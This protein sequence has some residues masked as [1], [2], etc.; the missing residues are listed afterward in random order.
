MAVFPPRMVNR[1]NKEK[2]MK[3]KL[4]IANEGERTFVLVLETGED[5][6]AAISRFATEND[7]GGASLTAIGAFSRATVGF[8]D[9]NTK[10]YQK[11]P[12]NEQSEVLSAIGD[13]AI[14]DDS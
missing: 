5:A 9:F 11:I 2:T 6:F 7:I 13:I 14:D 8:F 3:N 1:G 10:T 12:I 4:L